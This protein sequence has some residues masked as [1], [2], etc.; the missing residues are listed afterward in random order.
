MSKHYT[1]YLLWLGC[2]LINLPFIANPLNAAAIG[3][4][5]GIALQHSA[6]LYFRNR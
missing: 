5:L 2:I 1:P 6:W 3:F 4:T